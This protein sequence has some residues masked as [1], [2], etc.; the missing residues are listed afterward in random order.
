MNDITAE[1]FAE[2]KENPTT[3]LVYFE[4]EQLRNSLMNNLAQGQTLGQRADITHGLTSKL[5]GQI[6]GLNQLLNLTFED[7]PE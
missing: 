4:V 7:T 2:W 1:Q 6:E 5:V 3:K